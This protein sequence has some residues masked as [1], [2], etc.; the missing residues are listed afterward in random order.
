MKLSDSLLEER[1]QLYP[2]F[3][4]HIS[5]GSKVSSSRFSMKFKRGRG[6][7]K[8]RVEKWKPRHSNDK[9][10][11]ARQSGGNIRPRHVWLTGFNLIY[12]QK[13]AQGVARGPG[14]WSQRSMETRW[15]ERCDLERSVWLYCLAGDR[16]MS[17]GQAVLEWS[18]VLGKVGTPLV[19]MRDCCLRI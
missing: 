14:R 2:C 16:N 11:C 12:D 1:P 17:T 18:W 13:S 6:L 7:H 3:D 4:R 10:H 8:W 9:Q 19:H 5:A 15:S